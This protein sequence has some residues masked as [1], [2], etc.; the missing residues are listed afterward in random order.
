MGEGRAC[1][2]IG[3]K[4]VTGLVGPGVLTSKEM[5][6]LPYFHRLTQRKNKRD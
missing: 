6:Y 1:E 2:K 4:E 3:Q 5:A